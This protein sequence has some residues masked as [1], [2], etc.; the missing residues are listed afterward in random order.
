MSVII[1]GVKMPYSCYDCCTNYI[2]P[3]CGLWYINKNGD[4]RRHSNCPLVEIPSPHGIIVDAKKYIK[5]ITIG[6]RGPLNAEMFKGVVLLD[7][8]GDE[9]DE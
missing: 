8:E 7:A 3:K 2:F 4:T 9:E 5:S 1:K 6:M